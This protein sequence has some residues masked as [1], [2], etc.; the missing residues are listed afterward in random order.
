MPLYTFTDGTA[1]DEFTFDNGG[2]TGTTGPTLSQCRT[3]YGGSLNDGSWWN[4]NSNNW[5]DMTTNGIQKWIVPQSGTYSIEVWG[6]AGGGSQYTSG[7]SGQKIKSEFEL[8]ENDV[9]SILV[10]QMGNTITHYNS[11]GGGGT[12]VFKSG[13]NITGGGGGGSGYNTTANQGSGSLANSHAPAYS[14]TATGGNDGWNGK[15]SSTHGIPTNTAGGGDGGTNGLGGKVAVHVNANSSSGRSGGGGGGYSGDGD[16]STYTGTSNTTRIGRGGLAFINGGVGGASEV[17]GYVM[18]GGFGGGGSG[19]WHWW[20]GGGGGGGYSG[21]GGGNHYGGGGGGSS[22]SSAATVTTVGTNTSHGR[23][24][25]KAVAYSVASIPNNNI[26][27]SIL[28]SMYI[29]SGIT[30]ATGHANLIGALYTFTAHTFTN[31]GKSGRNGPTYTECINDY[32]SSGNW[33]NNTDYYDVV[34]SAA[35]NGIQLWTVPATGDYYI[36]AYGASGGDS[37]PYNNNQWLGGRG[38]RMKGLFTLTGGDKYMIL[39][40]QEG[41]AGVTPAAVLSLGSSGGGGTFFIKG[42]DYTNGAFSN[43]LIAAGGGGGG[44]VRNPEG[45]D[46]MLLIP[47]VIP[48]PLVVAAGHTVVV[49]VEVLQLLVGVTVTV[50]RPLQ[51]DMQLLLVDRAVSTGSGARILGLMVVSVVVVEPQSMRVEVVADAM[52]V[53]VQILIMPLRMEK[54]VDLVIRARQS[55]TMRAITGT[56]RL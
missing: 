21:G 23:V 55:S 38:A 25:I 12:T 28:K 26:S 16:S 9:I 43:L 8:F 52:V 45:L 33:W 7:G 44:D 1:A 30:S 14:G 56:V 54:A 32:G 11:G 15:Y 24:I 39:I 2:I 18:N 20:T 49:E 40:G 41:S 51:A 35:S 53:Q 3:S 13:L 22:T 37:V 46:K 29:D 31:C 6:A 47:R 50:P 4:D 36:D 17:V 27:L 5:L 10:G 42:D 48:A 19:D 34:G